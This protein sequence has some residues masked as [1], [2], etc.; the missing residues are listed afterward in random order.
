MGKESTYNM[1]KET[2]YA[3]IAL[4]AG[5]V[6]VFIL[7]WLLTRKF[8]IISFAETGPIGD[9]I[10]GIT[11]PISG[12]LGAYLIFLALKAQIVANKQI[13]NQIDEQNKKETIAKKI[14]ITEKLIDRLETKIINFKITQ[15]DTFKYN[16]N[17]KG[18]EGIRA[19]I[20]NFLSYS[21]GNKSI[22]FLNGYFEI[23]DLID[24][25]DYAISKIEELPINEKKYF[26]FVFEDIINSLSYDTGIPNLQFKDISYKNKSV[27]EFVNR[28]V[29]LFRRIAVIKSE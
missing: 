8:G 7:P 13:Q 19:V 17:I 16:K 1:K 18:L 23:I 12:L 6:L 26:I 10:G 27:A 21:E 24:F 5:I 11:A 3:K 2:V 4:V 25:C 15:P 28:F 22:E 9:T 14:L 29:S 20:I